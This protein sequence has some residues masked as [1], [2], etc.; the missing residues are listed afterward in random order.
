VL[1]YR[2]T[3]G[4]LLGAALLAACS[5]K[6]SP[7]GAASG[8]TA[9][10]AAPPT[11]AAAAPALASLGEPCGA[12]IGTRCAAPLT[13]V[14]EGPE[15]SACLAL[16]LGG[17]CGVFQCKPGEACCDPDGNTCAPAG[18]ECTPRAAAG[19]RG[20]ICRRGV[21]TC[22]P[23]LRCEQPPKAAFGVCVER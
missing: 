17:V 19:R 22:D 5:D 10:S 20:T 6:P 12:R 3:A 9:P 16:P 1:T 23:L 7:D 11:S 13:C 18:A 14:V 2:P 8:S 21:E 4:F 15:A